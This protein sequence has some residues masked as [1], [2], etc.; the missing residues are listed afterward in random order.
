MEQRR[1]W[2]EPD[3]WR[4]RRL[5]RSPAS[6]RDCIAPGKLRD[7]FKVP[8][9]T[10]N[11]VA[12]LHLLFD[13]NQCGMLPYGGHRGVPRCGLQFIRMQGRSGMTTTS[14]VSNNVR[15]TGKE[16]R[17]AREAALDTSGDIQ[18]ELQTLRSDC[19]PSKS[20][21]SSPTKPARLGGVHVPAS[22]ALLPMPRERAARRSTRCA[23]SLIILSMRSTN[24][25]RTGLTR[26]SHFS[27]LSDFC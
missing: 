17:E 23:M 7:V 5:G 18:S 22:T 2:A 9:R 12:A 6:V 8:R 24:R 19:S 20:A 3:W 11:P 16:A 25:S 26:H 10:V 13:Q 27:P 1:Q 15:E 21:A 4:N 14:S